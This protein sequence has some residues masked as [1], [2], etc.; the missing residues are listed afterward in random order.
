MASP[1]AVRRF[2]VAGITLEVVCLGPGPALPWHSKLAAFE[3][4]SPGPDT[5]IIRHHRSAFPG[6]PDGPGRPIYDHPP[7]KIH[8]AEDGWI[9]RIGGEGQGPIQTAVFASDYSRADIYTPEPLA[10]PEDGFESLTLLPTDQVLLAP[11]LAVRGGCLLHSAGAI[12]GG[13]GW[14]FA[15]HS[16]AGKSTIV[17]MLKGRAEILCDDRIALRP[18]G[19]GGFRIHG[20]WSHGDVPDISPASAPL[21]ELFLLRKSTRDE[22]SPVTDRR[23]VARHLLDLVI[24]PLATAAWWG[25]TLGA[26]DR[27][28]ASLRAWDLGFGLGGGILGILDRVAASEREFDISSPSR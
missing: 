7:Y 20:T 23:A 25:Q 2:R 24:K 1:A 21:T 26:I 5:V 19:A 3:V 10:I 13:A 28:S 14:L 8:A 16:T 27:L 9:Y 4:D 17:G 18:D 22:A 12:R 6:S 15:G 11:L